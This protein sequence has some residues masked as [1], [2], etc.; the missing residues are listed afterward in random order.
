[1]NEDRFGGLLGSV[2]GGLTITR[3]DAALGIAAM[4]GLLAVTAPE[5]QAAPPASGV[6]QPLALHV[7]GQRVNIRIDLR[8]GGALNND[9][10]EY[11]V[12]VNAGIGRIDVGFIDRPDPLLNATGVKG[13]GEVVM[14][15]VAAASGNAIF[16]AD[17][18]TPART[19]DADRAP[20]LSSPTAT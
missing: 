6:T 17:R 20:A 5:G 13:I 15:G 4:T 14:V 9:L 18:S 2:P 1:M 3:R 7:N 16:H 12:P 19:A 11:V 10:S 8:F